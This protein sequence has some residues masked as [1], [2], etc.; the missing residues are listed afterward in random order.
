MF[1]KGGKNVIK[2]TY[3]GTQGRVL[4][5]DKFHSLDLDPHWEAYGC[6]PV[7]AEKD[8]EGNPV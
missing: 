5:G 3:P 2:N 4:K 6:R 8:E 1:S 7:V